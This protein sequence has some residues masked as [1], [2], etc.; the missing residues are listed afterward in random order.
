M[1]K[2]VIGSIEILQQDA[3]KDRERLSCGVRGQKIR[4]TTIEGLDD[5][6]NDQQWCGT[7]SSLFLQ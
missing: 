2:S 5:L 3:F 4:N 7:M 6:K 1:L